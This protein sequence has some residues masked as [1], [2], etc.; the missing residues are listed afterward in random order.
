VSPQTP[1]VFSHKEAPYIQD[2]DLLF[3]LKRMKVLQ[4]LKEE[5]PNID[6]KEEIDLKIT[7]KEV[8]Y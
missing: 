1:Q 4:F 5:T 8:I 7:L 6:M 2:M 3:A